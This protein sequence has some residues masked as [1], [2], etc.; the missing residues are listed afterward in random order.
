MPA[1][2]YGP[3][4]STHSGS[5]TPPHTHNRT[6]YANTSPPAP[7]FVRNVYFMSHT[8]S[9]H[10]LMV[11][12]LWFLL[13]MEGDTMWLSDSGEGMYVRTAIVFPL[14]VI[15]HAR[16]HCRHDSK[17]T[18]LASISGERGQRER[19]RHAPAGITGVHVCLPCLNVCTYL[20]FPSCKRSACRRLQKYM[21]KEQT[22]GNPRHKG[23]CRR[24]LSGED[25]LTC[26]E[27][28]RTLGVTYDYVP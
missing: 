5:V 24:L 3:I 27:L 4:P 28:S 20:F 22:V 11:Q 26:A 25:I 1:H 21:W 18:V 23:T 19:T 9:I 12:C 17:T 14:S 8:R 2:V 6:P 15:N 10:R 7:V 16:S 13:Y